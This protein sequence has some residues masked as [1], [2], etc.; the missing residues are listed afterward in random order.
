V[1][2]SVRG[3]STR[4]EKTAVDRFFLSDH[5]PS[6]LS[7]T[8]ARQTRPSQSAEFVCLVRAS[9]GKVKISTTVAAKDHAR[10]V[11]SYGTI[12]RA[13]MDGLKKKAKKKK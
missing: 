5:P 6:I 10:F 2:E 3:V 4:K 1:R 12:L 7:Q 11:E 9:D 13:Q 8:H